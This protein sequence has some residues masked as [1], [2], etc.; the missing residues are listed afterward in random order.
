M[1]G[2]F[3]DLANI[4]NQRDMDYEK[5][6]QQEMLNDQNE[7]TLESQRR[8]DR[9][10]EGLSTRLGGK[11]P[12]SVR[13]AYEQMIEA[14]YESGDP[15]SAMEYQAKADEYDQAQVEKRRKEF[16]GAINL[17]P[18]AGYDRIE[19]LYPGV[20]SKEDYNRNQRRV[21]EGGIKSSDM[22]IVMNTETGAKNRIPWSMAGE[23][24]QL[25][26]EVEPSASRQQEILD[27]IERKRD[28]LANPRSPSIGK[29]IKDF[30]DPTA[31]VPRPSPTPAPQDARGDRARQGPS[32]GDQ[33]K[34]IKRERSVKGK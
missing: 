23:A 7:I 5:L 12:T 14:A 25:G 1:G 3:G 27:S 10:R 6:Q 26:W 31:P 24:Q 20:L 30:F 2:E 11:T 33:V 13:E 8:K 32:V 22:V 28:E 34:V 17:A 16:S 21:K 15:I 9:T 18:D 29:T 19:E 4:M